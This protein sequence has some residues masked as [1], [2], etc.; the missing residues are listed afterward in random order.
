MTGDNAVFI[1]MRF[2]GL[3]HLI[4]SLFR[5]Q[6]PVSNNEG[7]CYM[8][9]SVF[10]FFALV[11]VGWTYHLFSS[12]NY[13]SFAIMIFIYAG[14]LIGAL[15]FHIYKVIDDEKHYKKCR[16]ESREKAEQILSEFRKFLTPCLVIDSNI[17]M[18]EGYN[19]FFLLLDYACAAHKYKLSLFGV[20]FDEISNIKKKSKYGKGKGA[21]ARL[22]INRIEE[23]QKQN[24]LNISPI[25]V[26]ASPGAYADPVIIKI[27]VAQAKKGIACTFISDDKELR[28]RVRQHLTDLGVSNWSIVEMDSM[29]PDC[30]H[31]ARVVF[32]HLLLRAEYGT[33]VF[34]EQ[35][36]FPHDFDF[37][38]W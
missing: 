3:H 16:K 7:E 18:N 20:Q 37:N 25:A 30:D 4:S 8:E 29:M 26:D 6:H 15:I 2:E 11:A 14:I 9:I 5:I 38:L 19:S 21:S 31:F 33:S 13:V 28:I 35:G 36:W 10:I 12:G 22:A 23:F 17:W 32:N 24:K 34:S 27:L 1:L